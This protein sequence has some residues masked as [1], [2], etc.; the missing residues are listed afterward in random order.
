[1]RV[2]HERAHLVAVSLVARGGIENSRNLCNAPLK[3]RDV[4]QFTL[5]YPVF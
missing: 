1:V 3:Q 5:Y 4:T 2:V